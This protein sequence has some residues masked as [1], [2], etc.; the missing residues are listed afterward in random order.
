[1]ALVLRPGAQGRELLMMQRAEREGDP[2]SGQMAFPGGHREPEDPDLVWTAI[3]ES[4]EEM[5]L[6]LRPTQLL[7]PLR[8]V[9]S[10]RLRSVGRQRYVHAYVFGLDAVPELRLNH[11][12][13][14]AHWFSLER[15]L[16]GDGR[17]DFPLEYEGQSFRMPRVDL[18]GQR[19]WG[20]SL[21]LLDQLLERIRQLP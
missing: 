11:E 19:I 3:R 10:P 5:G 13:A 9:V 1:M 15:L 12:V 7:G 17:G 6:D 4:Q 2:W 21:R 16:R 18:Q 20:M 8:P 14:G